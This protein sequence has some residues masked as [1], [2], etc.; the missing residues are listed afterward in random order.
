MSHSSG[1]PH[2]ALFPAAC[3]TVFAAL[4]FAC[5]GAPGD[6]AGSAAESVD[7]C[8]AGSSS[9]VLLWT[10]DADVFSI[11]KNLE[12]PPPCTEYYVTIPLLVADKTSF[13]S[14]VRAE[15]AQVH[16]KGPHFH[17]VAEFHWG[18]WS[19][20]IA[21]SPGTRNWHLAGAELR[22]R[23]ELAGFSLATAT[24][25][26][27]LVNEL[28]STVLESKNGVDK[29]VVRQH[30]LDAVA[31]LHEGAVPTM[32]FVA[33]AGVGSTPWADMSGYK[34][35]LESFLADEPFWA[36]MSEHVR[37]WGE[38][39]YAD[40]H[41]VCVGSATVADRARHLNDFVF[42]LPRLAAAGPA[43]AARARAFLAKTFTPFLNGSW[44]TDLGYGNVRIDETSMSAFLS[45]EVY[46]VEA[47]ATHDDVPRNLAWSWSPDSTLAPAAG[48]D[49]LASRLAGAL[50]DSFAHGASYACSPSGAYT[51]CQC[52]VPGASFTEAWHDL[53]LAW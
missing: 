38:E 4:T 22:R 48:V 44:M 37:G 7:T 16:A 24:D 47:F 36:G 28:P 42:H 51:D 52:D 25:D 21:R 8:S 33:R 2:R 49:S 39:V 46:S 10:D 9:Q 23:M 18:S 13:H 34:A 45:Q 43:S 31:G 50:S 14:N 11:A 1:A 5:S 35:N 15:I 12:A 19:D 29:S 26:T 30:A 41:D 32:G 6:R 53:F 3:I 40:P 27:W 17:A 20:W